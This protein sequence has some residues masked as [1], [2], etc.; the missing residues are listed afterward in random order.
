MT[1]DKPSSGRTTQYSFRIP[2]ASVAQLDELVAAFE[3]ESGRPESRTSVLLQLI[4]R[5]HLRQQKKGGKK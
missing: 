1:D 3:A 4:H 2:D 5:E